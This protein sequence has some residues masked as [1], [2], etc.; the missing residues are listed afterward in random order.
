M[1]PPFGTRAHR[2][3]ATVSC[4]SG[5]LHPCDAQPRARPLSRPRK[6]FAPT[7]AGWQQVSSPRPWPGRGNPWAPW[8]APPP[9][10]PRDSPSRPSHPLHP[11]ELQRRAGSRQPLGSACS[12]ARTE[13]RLCSRLFPPLTLEAATSFRRALGPC[14]RRL[15]RLSPPQHPAVP[16]SLSPFP[17]IEVLLTSPQG[18]P[19]FSPGRS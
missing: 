3:C 16:V 6:D 4:A 19:A 15:W 5:D 2:G 12:V 9:H 8:T 11:Q 18:H 14:R 1:P 13:M 17:A 7:P 10:H